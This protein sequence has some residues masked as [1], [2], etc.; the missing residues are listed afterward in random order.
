MKLGTTMSEDLIA[1][2]TTP[3]LIGVSRLHEACMNGNLEKVPKLL[4]TD[5]YLSQTEARSKE[6]SFH[7]LAISKALDKLPIGVLN[8]QNLTKPDA[9]GTSVLHIA[10]ENGS[11]EQIPKNL[12][13]REILLEGDTRS[14]LH[15]AARY[16]H[17][18]K[19]PD[20]FLPEDY[21]IEI[22]QWTPFHLAKCWGH[23][24]QLLGVD[25]PKSCEKSVDKEWWEK[26]QRLL[27]VQEELIVNT[28]TPDLDLF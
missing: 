5:E 1:E 24:H 12:L 10:A 8:H 16:G 27:H 11:I 13:T 9:L 21:L 17:L 3:G 19:L 15:L 25:L 28:T 2:W 4:I 22:N 14:V 18:D 26:N 20:V 6:T 7:Y 23:M